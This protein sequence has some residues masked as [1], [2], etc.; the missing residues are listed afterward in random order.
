MLYLI[1]ILFVKLKFLSNSFLK[2]IGVYFFLKGFS[3]DQIEVFSKSYAKQIKYN[4]LFHDFDFNRTDLDIYIVSASYEIYLNKIFPEN[5]KIIGSKLSFKNGY[6][7]K[8]KFNNYA[9]SKLLSLK[10]NNIFKIDTLF[11]DSISDLAL[12][13]ISEKI[14]VVYKDSLIE[15]K[16]SNNFKDYFQK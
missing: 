15:F 11:T 8:L 16:D 5:V 6:V 14:V 10:K 12:A 1:I 9:E 13:K 4:R 2:Q 3:K 7:N